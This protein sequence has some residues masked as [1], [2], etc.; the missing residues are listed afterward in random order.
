MYLVYKKEYFNKILF[1]ILVF[2]FILMCLISPCFASTSLVFSNGATY[3]LPDFS[4]YVD[5]KEYVIFYGKNPNLGD[6]FVLLP[7]DSSKYQVLISENSSSTYGDYCVLQLHTLNSDGSYN[8]RKKFDYYYLS[9][10]SSSSWY[11][12][13]TSDDSGFSFRGGLYGYYTTKDLYNTEFELFSQSTLPKDPFFITSKDELSSGKFDVLK[14]DSGDLD[15]IEDKFVFNIYE[16]IFIGDGVYNDYKKK[17]FMLDKESSYRYIANLN[18]YFNIPQSNLG[19]DLSNGKRYTFELASRSGEKYDS[20]TFEIGGLTSEEEEQ[21]KEDEMSQKLDDQTDAIKENTETNKGIW[22]TIKDILSYINPFS[23]NFFVY[24]LIELL[25]DA[26]KSLF[27]P[28]DDFF[29]TYFSD[30]KD[31]LSDR[32]GFLF[33]PFELII[34]ILNK[35]L[36]IDF[37][38]P[39]FNIPDIIEPFS[40]KK[41]ISATTFNLNNLLENSTW[42]TIHSIYLICVDAFIIFG[43]VSLFKKKYEE[44]TTQ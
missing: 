32:L 15:N 14:I 33:Y 40:N 6:R 36:N 24:K 23:E 26:I 18:I 42:N 22:E 9:S 3:N 44:V 29:S 4:E 35:I 34:D 30:L 31:W 8:Y 12:S 41:L 2:I 1:T 7:Y 19:I 27:I 37:S 10:L 11:S 17:S 25:V 5:G 43:L 38:N 16:N 28:S 39:I 20:V 13:T 21:N